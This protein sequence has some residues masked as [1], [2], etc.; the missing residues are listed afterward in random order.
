M[1]LNGY[2]LGR[3][4]TFTVVTPSGTLTLNGLT[5]FKSKPVYEKLKS[6][7]LN[8][9]VNN[10]AIPQGHTGSFTI[11]RSDAQTDTYFAQIE[12]AY[13]ANGAT[14][15]AGTILET[16][17]EA[18]GSISQWQYNGVV[19]MLEDSGDFEADKKVVQTINFEASTKVRVA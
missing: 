4:A 12:A 5:G 17:N 7:P 19:L 18:D 10:A 3:D 15:Q 1:P 14:M 16:I 6:K 8:G 11:D 9:V 2:T 13:L